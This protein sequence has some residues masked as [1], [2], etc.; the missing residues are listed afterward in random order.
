MKFERPATVTF[1]VEKLTEI[2]NAVDVDTAKEKLAEYEKYPWTVEN[3]Q[4]TRNL[5]EMFI[6]VVNVHTMTK[7]A[8]MS[9][10]NAI[11]MVADD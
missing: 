7:V 8:G 10:E 9:L 5:A 1:N 11:I 3:N 2:V 4:Q 6:K